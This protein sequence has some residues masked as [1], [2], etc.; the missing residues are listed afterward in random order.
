MTNPEI[1]QLQQRA[2]AKAKA[3]LER[4][5]HALDLVA[6]LDPRDHLHW[7]IIFLVPSPQPENPEDLLVQNVGHILLCPGQE[8]VFSM[9]GNA[10]TENVYRKAGLLRELCQ[11]ID[12]DTKK[13]TNE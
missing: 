2:L 5:R 4:H 12:A 13:E 11:E 9:R 10:Q 3:A 6:V 7:G 1:Q 8:C